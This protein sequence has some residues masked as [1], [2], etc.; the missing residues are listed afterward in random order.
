MISLIAAV[1]EGM[2]LGYKGDLVWRLSVDLRRF[3]ELTSG[4][5]ILMGHKT[6]TSLP[7][8][9]PGRKHVVLVRNP[10]EFSKEVAAKP[11]RGDSS[12]RP[13]VVAI[14][15]L[16]EFVDKYKGVPEELFVIGGGSIYKQLISEADKL[17]L[18]EIHASF[19]EA[20]VYFPSF[21]KADFRREVVGKGYEDDLAYDFVVYTRK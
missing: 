14:R 4:K 18:T 12:A 13:E 8:L 6:F 19:P 11:F 10:E 7:S 3:R 21:D 20:D 15:E 1:G 16:F 9:L 5:T 2:E 17:Y